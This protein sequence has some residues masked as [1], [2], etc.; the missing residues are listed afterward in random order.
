[1]QED[2]WGMG[3]EEPSRVSKHRDHVLLTFCIYFIHIV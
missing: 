3:Q 1:M 2:T